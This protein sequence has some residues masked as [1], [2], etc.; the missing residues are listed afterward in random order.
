MSPSALDP[1]LFRE[2]L[3]HY[4]TGV[5]IVTGIHPDGEALAM[6][7]GTFTSVS[8][9]PPLV[10]FLPMKSSGT[11]ARLRECSTMC[12]NVLTGKQESLGRTI[13]MRKHDKLADTDWFPSPSGDPVL[14]DSLAWLDVRLTDTMEAGDHWIAMCSVA[15]MAVT[16]PIAPLIFFQGGY[17]SF[18]IPS[19]IARIEADISDAVRDAQHARPT[20]ERLA[21]DFSCEATILTVV[22]E[23]ELAS[24][25]SAVGSGVDNGDSLGLRV[26]TIPPIADIHMAEQ[27]VEEQERWLAR[28]AGVG[29]DMEQVF[30]DRLEFAREHKYLMSFIPADDSHPYEAVSEATHRYGRGELT[31]AEER[32][33]RKRISTSPVSYRVS[34][35][36]PQGTY[37]VGMLVANIHDAEGRPVH[38]LRLAHFPRRA[39]GKDV[40]E[41]IE[42]LLAAT[43]ELRSA[44]FPH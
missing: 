44:M 16:N 40:L 42:R 28:A 34:E 23:N 7:V 9:E 20:L 2:V 30:R 5:V 35:I 26:P 13:A 6:V 38:M 14:A 37:N 1:R 41:W 24:I 39:S 19:L 36:D 12:I 15:D 18:V 29:D 43:T 17:G 27:P 11:F 31:P 33:I 8:L 32:E 10:A 22:N 25:A 3:G 21:R 4:P